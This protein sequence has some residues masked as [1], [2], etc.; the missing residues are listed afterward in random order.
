MKFWQHLS[1]SNDF[2]KCFISEGDVLNVDQIFIT[3]L[4]V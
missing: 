1:R 4:T 3:F 2:K